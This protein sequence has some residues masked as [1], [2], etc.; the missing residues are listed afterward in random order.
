MVGSHLEGLHSVHLDLV[1][2]CHLLLVG[3]AMV[4]SSL[5][6]RHKCVTCI[7][8]FPLTSVIIIIIIIIM[9]IIIII[10]IIVI[11]IMITS[12]VPLLKNI[13]FE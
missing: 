13:N 7:K 6:L 3:Q 8:I 9:I 11:I 1:E 12:C 10:M 2:G 5:D 4:I